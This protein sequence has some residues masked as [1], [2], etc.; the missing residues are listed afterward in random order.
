MNIAQ[1]RLRTQ[2]LTGRGFAAPDEAVHWFGAVQAQDYP[3][4]LWALGLRTERATEAS[5][6][7]AIA[8]RRIVRSWP[9]RGT[10]HFTTPE[11]LRWMLKWC[12][13]Q[14][15]A[16]VGARFRQFNLDAPTFSRSAKVIVKALEGGRQLTRPQLYTHLERVKIATRG[17]RGSHI[18]FRLA[19]EG[20]ICF[21]GYA[22]KQPTMALL[23][24]WLPASRVLD[25]DEAFAEL[26][27]RYYGSHAPAT[28]RDFTW[29]SGLKAG[30]AKRA[31]EA[32]GIELGRTH[33]SAPTRPA[34]RTQRD[35]LGTQLEAP[36]TSHPA[37]GTRHAA[38]GTRHLA[39]SVLLLPPYDEYTVAYRDRSAALDPKHAA[40]TRNGIFH[41]IIVIDGRVAGTWARRIDRDGIVIALKPVAR[42]T[43]A[44]SRAIADAAA[45]Y[46]RFLGRPVRIL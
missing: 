36:G 44:Q 13:P 37:L 40:A 28:L 6:K 33:R 39:P 35:A 29:W 7:Q 8:D 2:R 20:L 5:V 15:L 42:P 21:A 9:L 30:D 16:R 32:A 18:I 27:R 11:D 25:R 1:Q 12:A 17:N 31:T 45:R 10:L 4:A 23:D 38:P 46:G 14:T 22:E 34:P 19:S 3:G 43:A 41:P 24:E 26:A